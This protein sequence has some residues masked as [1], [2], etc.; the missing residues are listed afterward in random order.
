MLLRSLILLLAVHAVA[1][2][3]ET[4][5]AIGPALI[6]VRDVP[7]G[8]PFSLGEAAKV[9]FTLSNQ[10]D[11]E[12]TYGVQAVTPEGYAFSG[13]EK[14]Y[15]P[16]PDISWFTLDREEVTIPARGK[17]EVDLTI[18][19]PDRPELRNRHWIVCIDAGQPKKKMMGAA[20]RLRAR[21]MLETVSSADAVDVA[22]SPH[23][24]EI[25]VTPGAV[26]M[27]PQADGRWTGEVRVR[28]NTAAAA[29][30]AI[31]PVQEVYAGKLAKAHRYF[32]RAD[33][34]VLDQRWALPDTPTFALATGAATTVHFAAAAVPAL[35]PGEIREEVVL[36]SRRLRGEAIP[37]RS[38][39][40]GD[41][42][43]ERMELVRLRYQAPAAAEPARP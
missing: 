6:L 20:L 14:G 17:V 21:I 28:N 38:F 7:I 37:E 40:L 29:D 35:K 1:L 12:A 13:F 42:T 23:A 25:A 22:A 39:T 19:I 24:A 3:G 10:S 18:S 2:A 11:V 27:Q 9:R 31:L 33:I 36:V 32:S 43:F 26:L 4:G 34:M 8:R 41:A 16:V 5:L 15:E 30:F